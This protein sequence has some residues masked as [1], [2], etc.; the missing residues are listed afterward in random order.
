M[1]SIPHPARLAACA[2]VAL[3]LGAS[4]HAV[5]C[6]ST[7]LDGMSATACRVDVHREDLRLLL[8]D[9]TGKPLQTFAALDRSLASQGLRV[10]FAMNAGMFQPNY[11]PVGLFIADGKQLKR[12]NTADGTDNFTL[13]PNG[14]FFVGARGAGVIESSRF[15][16]IAESVSL[17]TQS[18]PLLVQAGAIHPRLS[19]ASASRLIRNGVGV[20]KAGLVIFAISEDPMNLHEFARLFRD[21][22]HCPNALYFD[23]NVSSVYVPARQLNIQRSL[24]GPMITVV[25][26]TPKPGGSDAEAAPKRERP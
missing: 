24:L 12:L 16:A 13:K 7:Q 19:A 23:G 22:L 21:T 17:A 20:D 11:A 10:T 9:A 1:R 4:A 2:I 14:V 18:G 25:E 3:A 26:A 6:S 15:P 5:E 8:N